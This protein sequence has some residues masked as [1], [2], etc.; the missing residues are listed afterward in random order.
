[1]G[2]QLLDDQAVIEVK[3]ALKNV[4]GVYPAYA[5]GDNVN[6]FNIRG[7][8]QTEV[9]R[10]GMRDNSYYNTSETANLENIEVLKEPASI[11]YGQVEPGGLV[12]L[13][14]KEPQ[15]VQSGTLELQAGSFGLVRPSVDVTGPLTPGH[16]LSYRLNTVYQNSDSFR[17]YSFVDRAFVAPSISY[18]FRD[19]T[20]V[21]ADFDWFKN[22]S[23]FDFGSPGYGGRPYPVPVNFSQGGPGTRDDEKQ[24]RGVVRLVHQFTPNL[25]L[26][27]SF[28]GL[29]T[30]SVENVYVPTGI[31]A[32]GRTLD[33]AA[34]LLLY[35]YQTYTLQNDVH[36]SF[37]TGHVSHTLL[38]GGEWFHRIAPPFSYGVGSAASLDLKT[39][40]YTPF[41]A[42]PA[43]NVIVFYR[44]LEN[45]GGPYVQDLI[46][47]TS[48]LKVLAGLRYT[49]YAARTEYPAFNSKQFTNAHAFS[50]QFGVVYH[51][52]N[53]ISIYGSWAKS[54]VP[55][56]GASASGKSFQPE[57]GQQFEGGI[58]SE[59]LQGKLPG[60]LSLY[61]I[62]LTNVLVPDPANALFSVSAGKQ[63]SQ[64][65]ELDLTGKLTP[66]WNVNLNYAFLQANVIGTAE[67]ANIP[68]GTPL[69][70]DP[71]HGANLWTVYNVN[72]GLFKNL[73]F[74]GG[75]IGQ[76]Y[77]FANLGSTGQVSSL[78][79]STNAVLP[80]FARVDLNGSYGVMVHD[81]LRYKLQINL[82]NL[83]DRHYYEVGSVSGSIPG[84]PRAVSGTLR[85]FF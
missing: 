66:N 41:P 36:Y 61:H 85:M 51:L 43:P 23:A 48:R 3:D 50:P 49:D 74:G 25:S 31:E 6:L 62:T 8:Q 11:L 45:S 22:H 68:V 80:G 30:K 42:I 59:L 56:S 79:S 14:T 32:D 75:L 70:N 5:R 12:N 73:T 78:S 57:I 33:R 21:N 7:F 82:N 27:E 44:N 4:S 20:H 46:A 72:R 54:F 26:H 76:T 2:R 16:S 63:R 35:S 60:T 81:R 28:S 38:A 15:S 40:V 47:V 53:P 77:R 83:L 67:A 52:A 1:M 58:K 13:I 34:D 64:G 55:V 29:S 84:S 37:R 19:K 39:P 9:F 10:N 65:V 24:V 18:R 17:D 69:A 71:R